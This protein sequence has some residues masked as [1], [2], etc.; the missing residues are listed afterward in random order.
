MSCGS[1]V[2]QVTPRRQRRRDAPARRMP[3]S[4]QRRS[5]G[6]AIVAEHGSFSHERQRRRLFRRPPPRRCGR[7]RRGVRRSLAQPHIPRPARRLRSLCLGARR[8]RDRTRAAVGA[9][10]ARYGRLSGGVL[11][12]DPGRGRTRAGQYAA[13][14]RTDRLYP[15]RQPR[16]G[17]PNFG[18]IATPTAARA[19]GVARSAPHRCRGARRRRGRAWR[20]SPRNRLGGFPR[21]RRERHAAGRG[22]GRRG[23]V[24]ALFVRIDRRAEGGEARPCQPARH[25]RYLRRARARHPGRR[26]RVL[27]GE[28]VLRLRAWQRHDLSDV[29]RRLRR[30]PA[31]A[32]DAGGG[33]RGDAPTSS[34]DLRRGADLVRGA[35]RPSRARSRRRIGPAT[36]LYLGRR[37]AAGERRAALGGDR[38]RRHPR[39]HRL[40][41]DAA[42]LPLEPARRG[43]LRH[44]RGRW[45]RATSCGSSTKRAAT[46]T[47]EPWEN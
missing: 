5:A 41:R 14:A 46:S 25:R 37:A 39:R 38:R 27:G 7:R 42:H 33:A 45:C 32:A 15:R 13:H 20:R 17:A 29:G 22:I 9:C 31:R 8:E 4:G 43:T 47:M 6:F 12:R 26:R 44:D 16:R 23:G 24:L 11:G 28:T 2:V 36:A 35:A 1:A 3:R 34:D 10:H 18:A 30:T 19:A 40:D 21:R